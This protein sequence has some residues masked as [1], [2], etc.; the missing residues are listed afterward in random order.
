[1]RKSIHERAANGG[2]KIRFNPNLEM[3]LIASSEIKSENIWIS[4]FSLAPSLPPPFPNEI[5]KNDIEIDFFYLI[6][7]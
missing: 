2:K 4:S 7:S 6:D 1:M 3:K 5:I